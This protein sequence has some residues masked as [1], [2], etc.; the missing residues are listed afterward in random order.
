MSKALASGGCRCTGAD[1]FWGPG[2]AGALDR[3]PVLDQ[4]DGR[5]PG[6]SSWLATLVQTRPPQLW[7][8]GVHSDTHNLSCCWIL[9]CLVLLSVEKKR[10]ENIMPFGVNLMRSPV[11]YRAAQV[12]SVPRL[13]SQPLVSRYALSIGLPCASAFLWAYFAE[14]CSRCLKVCMQNMPFP[15]ASF[16]MFAA[17]TW[18]Y[19]SVFMTTSTIQRFSPC[20]LADTHADSCFVCS[21]QDTLPST[22]ACPLWPSR[23][24]DIECC[25]TH[26]RMPTSC[27][28]TS[29][30]IPWMPQQSIQTSTMA[31]SLAL[32]SS[33]VNEPHVSEQIWKLSEELF[34]HYIDWWCFLTPFQPKSRLVIVLYWYWYWYWYFR[35]RHWYWHFW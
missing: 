4:P 15:S 35:F 9:L 27:L 25:R 1:V 16:S 28:P 11:S 23:Q 31:S 34:R 33:E 19:I 20:V 30:M 5:Q 7:I 8:S 21:C 10:K 17:N 13:A 3:H 18:D 24:L 2:L 6:P 32:A 22:R 26:Q 29:L 12:P 14:V